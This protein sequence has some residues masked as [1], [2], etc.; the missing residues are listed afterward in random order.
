MDK[1]KCHE[2]K[3]KKREVSEK[4]IKEDVQQPLRPT[5]RAL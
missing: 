5:K 3:E 4:P 1:A 2:G